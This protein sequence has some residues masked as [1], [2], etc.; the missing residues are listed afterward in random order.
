[1][2]KSTRKLPKLVFSKGRGTLGLILAILLP[3]LTYFSILPFANQTLGQTPQTT[4][5]MVNKN[6]PGSQLIGYPNGNDVT[7]EVKVNNVTDTDGLAGFAFKIS[8]DSNLVSIVDS[9]G[10]GKADTGTVIAGSFLTSTGKQSACG[11]GFLDKD[12]TTPNKIWLTFSCVTLGLTP[13]APQGTGVLATVKFKPKANLGTTILTLSETELID[14][15]QSA[16]LITHTTQNLALPVMK[17]A[18]FNGNGSVQLIGDILAVINR[19]GWT[20][21]NP[22]WDPKYDLNN[23]GKIN[24]I[25]DILPT[26]LQFGMYCTA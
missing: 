3:F 20:T 15:T 17:C 10:D 24:L 4:I 8:Y 19:F 25:G 23:D 21:S 26:I 6:Y 22:N 2:H 13:S 9:N 14:N 12:T 5:S 11:D 1:M 18:D 7:A 16:N